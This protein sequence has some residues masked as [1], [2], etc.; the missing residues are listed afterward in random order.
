MNALWAAL[1]ERAE[2]AAGDPY[3]EETPGVHWDGFFV[4]RAPE[5]GLSA[6][7][8]VGNGDGDFQVTQMGADR[9]RAVAV[10]LLQQAD[11]L[12]ALT[13]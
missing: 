6:W 13:K 9:L 2:A 12:D 4:Y 10:L 7:V 1:A 5:D 11:Q 3:D 8:G